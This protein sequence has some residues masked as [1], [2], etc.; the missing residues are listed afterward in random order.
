MHF[1][2]NHLTLLLQKNI[3]SVLWKWLVV[4]FLFR[5][6]WNPRRHN[7]VEGPFGHWNLHHGQGGA[8]DQTG[9]GDQ[10]L[11]TCLQRYV[12][13]IHRPN[14]LNSY[15][16]CIY[17]Y[18]PPYCEAFSFGPIQSQSCYSYSVSS[19]QDFGGIFNLQ[20]IVYWNNK[21]LALIRGST[22]LEECLK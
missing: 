9:T 22:I 12:P 21:R 14:Y 17:F 11:W 16:N 2:S 1:S 13:K 7:F 5:D 19:Y 20:F 10:V 18:L 8:P 3:L 6:I 4:F 15:F